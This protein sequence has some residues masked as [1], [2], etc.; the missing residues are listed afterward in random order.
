MKIK[1]LSVLCLAAA[2]GLAGCGGSD[3]TNKANANS[4][5][6]NNGT[7]TAPTMAP[8]AKDEAVQAAVEDA[9]KKANITGVTVDATQSGVTLRGTVEK[10]KMAEAVRVAQ[11][12]GKKAV[13]NELTEKQ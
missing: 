6:A 1:F 8:P 4:N 2:A 10:G 13:K 9:L 12:A 7:A 3:N 11:E 5:T